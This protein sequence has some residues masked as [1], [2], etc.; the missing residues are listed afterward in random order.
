LVIF[1]TRQLKQAQLEAFGA[2]LGRDQNALPPRNPLR[3]VKRKAPEIIDLT[4]D[5]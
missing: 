1:D 4:A 2:G 3:D 5:D